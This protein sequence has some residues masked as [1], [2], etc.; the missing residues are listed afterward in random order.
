MKIINYSDM[1]F[2]LTVG[3]LSSKINGI[4]TF[5]AAVSMGESNMDA[6]KKFIE[7]YELMGQMLVEYKELLD[8]DQKSLKEVGDAIKLQDID[9]KNLWR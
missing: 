2:R 9:V 6:M 5:P 1:Q 3:T 8:L 7:L 4:G